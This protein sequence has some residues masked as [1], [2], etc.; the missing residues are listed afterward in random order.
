MPADPNPQ[1]NPDLVNT[2]PVVVHL[3]DAQ[4]ITTEQQATLLGLPIRIVTRARHGHLPDRLEPD[5]IVR[6]SWAVHL[7]VNL[8]RLYAEPVA[9]T[10]MTRP[11]GRH[12]FDGQPPLHYVL[13]HGIPGLM[14][15][16][17]LLLSDLADY[18]TTTLAER[19]AAATFTLT[20]NADLTAWNQPTAKPHTDT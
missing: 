11:N 1:P 4:Q 2:L 3:L 18:P 20:I 5:Q 13:E 10:W 19:T 14:A 6:M 15:V 17:N 8:H 7:H 16:N 9:D 12:P